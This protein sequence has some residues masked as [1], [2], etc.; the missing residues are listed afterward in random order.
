LQ[1]NPNSRIEIFAD[2]D[3]PFT[4]AGN[5]V[6]IEQMLDHFLITPVSTPDFA[7]S[8]MKISGTLPKGIRPGP[9]YVQVYDGNRVESQGQAVHFDCAACP[10]IREVIDSE[11]QLGEFHPGTMVTIAR[12]FPIVRKPIRRGDGRKVGQ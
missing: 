12:G 3:L 10:V 1:L 7:E 4:V 11:R 9:A 8:A 2:G 6:N 5:R